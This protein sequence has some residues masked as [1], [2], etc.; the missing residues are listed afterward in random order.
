M[1]SNDQELLRQMVSVYL[2]VM[3]CDLNDPDGP[4]DFTNDMIELYEQMSSEAKLEWQCFQTNVDN[5]LFEMI[6]RIKGEK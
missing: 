3:I 2:G 1:N 6:N 5:H 4:P